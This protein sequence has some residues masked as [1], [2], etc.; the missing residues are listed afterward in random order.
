MTRHSTND[1]IA[2]NLDALAEAL[3]EA[4]MLA[5][6]ARTALHTMEDANLAV[7]TVLPLEQDLPMCTALIGTILALHRR[8][9]QGGAP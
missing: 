8:A 6:G 4:S 1:A 9:G 2:A 5:R 3:S 7:G